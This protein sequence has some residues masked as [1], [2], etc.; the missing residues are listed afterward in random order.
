MWNQRYFFFLPPFFLPFFFAA[1]PPHPHSA[2]RR[3]IAGYHEP[4]RA[5]TPA[6]RN[7]NQKFFCRS[8][9]RKLQIKIARSLHARELYSNLLRLLAVLVQ[10]PLLREVIVAANARASSCIAPLT[11]L[12][13]PCE[14][15]SIVTRR[16]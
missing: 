8:F 16:S 13:L 12:T 7:E 15:W 10:Y 2:P 3:A 5:I 6:Q 4:A 1:I 9:S 14:E 11:I